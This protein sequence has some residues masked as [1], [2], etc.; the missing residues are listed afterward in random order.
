M[1]DKRV[2]DLKQC[3]RLNLNSLYAVR[4]SFRQG[5][6][7]LVWTETH[8]GFELTRSARKEL[9]NL[10]M[11][12]FEPEYIVPFGVQRPIQTA[13]GQFLSDCGMDENEFH[14]IRNHHRYLT[15]SKEG[16]QK[17]RQYP[18]STFRSSSPTPF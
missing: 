8:V 3:F 10:G 7:V 14:E 11:H 6:F 9:G 2:A 4:A 15:R 5:Y 18:N 16:R 17:P 1:C 13:F 12:G